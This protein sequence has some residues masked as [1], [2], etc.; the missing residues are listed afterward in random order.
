MGPSQAILTINAVQQLDYF[1]A[2]Q[3]KNNIISFLLLFAYIIVS[4]W[5]LLHQ[6]II[7]LAVVLF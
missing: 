3:F 4:Y 6:V 5:S 7:D 1:V 2:S